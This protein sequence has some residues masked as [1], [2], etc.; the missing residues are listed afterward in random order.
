MV[1]SLMESIEESRSSDLLSGIQFAEFDAIF[2]SSLFLA[3]INFEGGP[4]SI[5]SSRSS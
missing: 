4:Y 1:L 2:A 3:I 5:A